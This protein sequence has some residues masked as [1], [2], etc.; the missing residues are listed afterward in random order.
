M[1]KLASILGAFLLRLKNK[2]FRA[3]LLVRYTISVLALP[4]PHGHAVPLHRQKASRDF[5]VSTW[6]ENRRSM[7]HAA[8]KQPGLKRWSA[9]T[10]WVLG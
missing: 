2:C 7:A 4:F 8:C 3:S 5:E 1:L 9:R 6:L 10:L